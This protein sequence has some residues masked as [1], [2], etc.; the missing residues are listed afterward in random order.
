MAEV[1]TPAVAGSFYP[2]AEGELRAE[3]RRHVAAARVAAAAPPKAVIAPHA[4]YVYSGPIAGSAFAA[5]APLRGRVARVVLLGPAHRVSFPGLA[6]PRARALATPLG[7]LPVDPDARDALLRLPQVCA[8]DHAHDGE[9]SLEVELPFVQEVLGEV[10]IAPMLVGGASDEET[11][12]A[13]DRVWDGAETCVVVSSDLSHYLPHEDAARLD[14]ETARAI[15]RLSA[16]D[17]GD[18]QACG[19][20]GLRALLLV[21]RA[22]GLAATTLDLR[23]SG[24]TAG[25][26]DAVVGYGAF[27]F[28]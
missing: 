13:L 8:S 15:E 19:S 22:R 18:E 12:E 7:M 3:V 1:R 14:R 6:L 11:A 21:A 2:R 28:G 4:G 26:R 24:D 9:H 5:L 16:G 10:A 25:T 20:T 17:V 27:C 23:S